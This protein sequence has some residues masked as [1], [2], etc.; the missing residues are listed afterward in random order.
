MTSLHPL[1]SLYVKLADVIFTI[2]YACLFPLNQTNVLF[3]Y[4]KCGPEATNIIEISSDQTEILNWKII[5]TNRF[6][7]YVIDISPQQIDKGLT[8]QTLILMHRR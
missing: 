4:K 5:E 7:R 3:F 2:W 6:Q 1:L 8:K